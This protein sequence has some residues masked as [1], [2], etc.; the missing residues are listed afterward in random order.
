MG[1]DSPIIRAELPTIRGRV[2]TTALQT[3]HKVNWG[4]CQV[5]WSRRFAKLPRNLSADC[6]FP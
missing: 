5:Y 4:S 2:K 6:V 3:A 1:W